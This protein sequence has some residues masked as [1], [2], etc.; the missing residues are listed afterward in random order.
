MKEVTDNHLF[1]HL[2]LSRYDS[3][4]SCFENR[5]IKKGEKLDL[6]TGNRFS[7]IKSGIL[8]PEG[9]LNKG[10]NLFLTDS[11]YYGNLPFS[12]EEPRGVMKAVADTE[13]LTADPAALTKALYSSYPALKGYLRL[14]NLS[15]LSVASRVE[16]IA[17]SNPIVI[18]T[19]TAG[20]YKKSA[21]LSVLVARF[22]SE[23]SPVIV[24]EL[25]REGI[26][27]F[28]V[29][30]ARITPPISEKKMGE[31]IESG[32]RDL[33]TEK[34]PGLHLINI[35]FGSKV[36]TNP[37]ILSPIVSYLSAHYSNIVIHTGNQSPDIVNEAAFISDSVIFLSEN[38]REYEKTRINYPKTACHG[39]TVYSLF[40]GRNDKQ[41]NNR[42]RVG[43]FPDIPSDID[44][45][46]SLAEWGVSVKFHEF[47]KKISVRKTLLFLENTGYASLGFAG[48]IDYLHKNEGHNYSLY[49]PSYALHLCALYHHNPALYVKNLKKI[50]KDPV[51]LSMLDIRFPGECL[52]SNRAL[53]S[54]SSS[55]PSGAFLEES[56][57]DV[58]TSFS[59]NK[60]RFVSSCGSFRDFSAAVL[61]ESPFFEP[62]KSRNG[63]FTLSADN[64]CLHPSFFLSR[65][66][67]SVMPVRISSKGQIYPRGGA[68]YLFLS[69]LGRDISPEKK[70]WISGGNIIIDA[71]TVKCNIKSTVFD[72]YNRWES[73]DTPLA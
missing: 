6:K 11:S 20:R 49:A 39:Q 43:S 50:F 48:L 63:V 27:V 53:R 8:Q 5:R 36:K 51:L 58:F 38:R 13:V 32:I 56:G 15:G 47:V 22:L 33:I 55:Y 14:M 41:M 1:S 64:G 24:I 17:S 54:F 28:D 71:E 65:G 21:A 25:S 45:I 7:I 60:T 29:C 35:S 3:F 70:K 46:P 4:F 34:N 30:G 62:F 26:S 67:G 66:F 40:T 12:D 72:L 10:E 9:V 69:G 19:V 73:F 18:S 59:N 61:C 31:G 68:E 52:L 42:G 16:K 57:L 44:D 37:S 2:A 23:Q